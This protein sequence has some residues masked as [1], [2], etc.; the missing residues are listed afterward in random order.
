MRGDANKKKGHAWD[1]EPVVV[2]VVMVVVVVVG[3]VV[4]VVVVVGV[5]VVQMTWDTACLSRRVPTC[6]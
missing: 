3:V 5:G 6:S 2:V 1:R 4:V